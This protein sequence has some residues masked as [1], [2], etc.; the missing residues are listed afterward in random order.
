METNLY[1]QLGVAR[2]A[3]P[4]QI[5]KA[6]RKRAKKSHPDGGGDAEAFVELRRAVAV[7]SDPERRRRYD[8]TGSTDETVIDDASQRAMSLL[9]AMLSSIIDQTDD[10]ARYDV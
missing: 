8:E 7:L 2:E 10:A 4:D 1:E 3:T 6:Y 5:R 9:A